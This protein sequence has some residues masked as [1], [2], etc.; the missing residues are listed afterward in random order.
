MSD[1]SPGFN[2]NSTGGPD[3]NRGTRRKLRIEVYDDATPPGGELDYQTLASVEIDLPATMEIPGER[4]I[5]AAK[6]AYRH[7]VGA[8]FQQLIEAGDP[9]E[10]P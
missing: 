8:D 2:R 3:M 6:R 10:T 7:M 4:V 9:Q 1:A 5:E